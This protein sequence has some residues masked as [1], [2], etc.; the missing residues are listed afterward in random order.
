MRLIEEM[1]LDLYKVTKE[2]KNNPQANALYLQ[3]LI[4]AYS[5]QVRMAVQDKQN[6]RAEGKFVA[7]PIFDGKIVDDEIIYNSVEGNQNV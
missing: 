5:A 1:A 3:T 2:F 4:K 6:S 7:H